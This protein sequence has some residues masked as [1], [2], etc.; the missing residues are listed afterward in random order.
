LAEYS[1][2]ESESEGAG[3]GW[4]DYLIIAAAV[5]IFVWLGSQAAVPPIAMNFS[6]LAAL[7][8]ILI[9]SIAACTW[10][11]WKRTRFS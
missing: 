5:G 8:I 6:W 9:A 4:W 3:R 10:V 11:L 7:A 1:G 2:Q